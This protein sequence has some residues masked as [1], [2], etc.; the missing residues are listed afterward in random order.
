MLLRRLSVFNEL[1]F[2]Q[3]REIHAEAFWALKAIKYHIDKLGPTLHLALD[4]DALAEFIMADTIAG[5][6]LR[7]SGL[8]RL[9]LLRERG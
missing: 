7:F 2:L 5:R 1:Y 9:R 3:L 4:D 8:R 6:E